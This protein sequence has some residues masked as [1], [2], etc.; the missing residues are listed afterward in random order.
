MRAVLCSTGIGKCLF[1]ESVVLKLQRSGSWFGEVGHKCGP[2]CIHAELAPEFAQI[3]L[4]EQNLVC[5]NRISFVRI[6][7]GLYE[8]NQVC[9]NIIW[10]VRIE[11][12]LYEQ[13]L[14]CWLAGLAGLACWLAGCLAGWIAGWL[15]DCLACWLAG[16]LAGWL[17]SENSKFGKFQSEY[18][19]SFLNLV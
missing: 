2:A 8:Q 16:L 18:I 11:F 17:T 19:F 7:F 3:G 9:T 5:T 14:V 4:Y 12:G 13:N 6:E 15:A 1:L 10:F